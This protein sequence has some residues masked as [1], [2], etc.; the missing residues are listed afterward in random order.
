[1]KSQT[2]RPTD[3]S[4]V[5]LLR[6]EARYAREK[7]DLYR[8]KSYGPRPTRPARLRELERDYE[9]AAERL[10]RAELKQSADTPTREETL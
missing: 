2:R 7:R 10:Q 1:M 3:S 9:L 6:D 8:A 5:A 4:A